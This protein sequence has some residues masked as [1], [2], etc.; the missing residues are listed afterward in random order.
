MCSYR[1]TTRGYLNRHLLGLHILNVFKCYIC[2]VDFVS[3]LKLVHHLKIA[4]Q[5]YKDEEKFQTTICD[6]EA[7][8]FYHCCFCKF[9]SVQRENVVEHLL[10]E[11]YDEFDM[12]NDGDSRNTS[13]P[14]SLD[15]LLLPENRAKLLGFKDSLP[16]SRKRVK[17]PFRCF[18]CK[19]KFSSKYWLKDHV[20]AERI[21]SEFEPPTKVQRNLV[22]GFYHCPHKKCSQVY[23]NRVLY[24]VHLA[25]DHSK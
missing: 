18:R 4:H 10:S 12:E 24:E 13:T 9:L 15:E 20:C 5:Q 17:Y 7:L 14:D 25:M 2:K 1:T 8:D 19:R 16:S 22:N 21:P 6:E 3:K 11:H 23:T